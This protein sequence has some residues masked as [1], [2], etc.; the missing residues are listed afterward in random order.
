MAGTIGAEGVREL[1]TPDAAIR[2]VD[3]NCPLPPEL[4]RKTDC[5][6]EA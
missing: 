1:E 5:D 4:S 6:G 2:A 3:Q